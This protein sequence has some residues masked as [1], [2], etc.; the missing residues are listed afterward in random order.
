MIRDSIIGAEESA[1][2]EI[3]VLVSAVVAVGETFFHHFKPLV[4]TADVEEES[5]RR[6]VHIAHRWVDESNLGV[7]LC[8]KLLGENNEKVVVVEIFAEDAGHIVHFAVERDRSA[9]SANHDEEIVVEHL[10]GNHHIVAPG[11]EDSKFASHLDSGTV[12]GGEDRSLGVVD[13]AENHTATDL[14][15][16]IAHAHHPFAETGFKLR[17]VGDADNDTGDG[18]E[19]NEATRDGNHLVGV[20]EELLQF[21]SEE[22]VERRRALVETE[23]DI[24]DVTLLGGIENTGNDIEVEALDGGDRAVGGSGG[25]LRQ[26]ESVLRHHSGIGRVVVADMQS[27]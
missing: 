17:L 8:A 19:R 4:P 2:L 27:E 1:V 5:R 18:V 13:T 3:D 14:L 26:C 24:G 10:V 21:V 6:N 15:G 11:V 16:K 7:L 25:F 22:R 9:A 12:E 23:D 20:D